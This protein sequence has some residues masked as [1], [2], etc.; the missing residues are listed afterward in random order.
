MTDP[1]LLF[2]NVTLGNITLNNRIGVAPMARVSATFEGLATT[3]MVSYYT[4]FARGGFGLIITEAI[5][6]DDK[7]SQGYLNNPG[8]INEEQT[9]A[10]KKVVDSVHQAG[11]KI[12]A[13]IMHA[14]ALSQGNRFIHETIGPSTVQPKGKQMEFYEGKGLYRIPKEATQQE[15]SEVIN[16]FVNT[17]KRAKTAGFDGVEIHGANGYLLDQFLTDYT[18]RRTD[19]YGGSTENRVRLLVE[20]SKAVREAVGQDFTLGIRISQGKV[21][22]YNYK[23]AGKEKDAEI[24]FSQLGSAGLDFIHVTEYKAWQPA[25]PKDEET[26]I[27]N[28]GLD[29]SDLSLAA[30][31]KKYGK[32]CVIAN[33]H[34]EDP[35]KAKEI[36]EKGEADIITLGKG[37]LA[38]HDWVNKVK[39]GEPLTK[40]DEEKVLRPDVKIKDF[41]V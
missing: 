23:W 6:T 25:F 30:L 8:L 11:A 10:W 28:S 15:L 39:N 22:D 4:S 33:G 20:V 34:L 14:G 7:Y 26:I 21:N 27:T 31:A 17:A 18:N 29:N 16:G 2:K 12:F 24:I 35:V 38:N 5:Y 41:E 37:A 40:F 13:Q 3:Q 19:E 9:Q 32:V 1:K 36:I